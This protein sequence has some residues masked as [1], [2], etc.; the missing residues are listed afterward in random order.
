MTVLEYFNYEVDLLDDMRNVKTAAAR[1]A[2]QTE[3]EKMLKD[4][5]QFVYNTIE[6]FEGKLREKA[7]AVDKLLRGQ[8]PDHV[9]KMM[10]DFGFYELEECD[11][12]VSP[13]DKF[14]HAGPS[15]KNLPPRRIKQLCSDTHGILDGNSASRKQAVQDQKNAVKELSTA[16]EDRSSTDKA[17]GGK[18]TRKS[19][20]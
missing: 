8:T 10:A 9:K 7:T 18:K 1:N 3:L 4:H 14:V 2:I 11:D 5:K 20:K 6:Q 13:P 16:V 17:A 12:T 15:G 19:R